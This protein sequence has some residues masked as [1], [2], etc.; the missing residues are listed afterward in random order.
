MGRGVLT[1]QRKRRALQIAM[2]FGALLT[3]PIST[4]IIGIYRCTCARSYC[5]RPL[6]LTSF[7]LCIFKTKNRRFRTAEWFRACDER[8][9]VRASASPGGEVALNYALVSTWPVDLLAVSPQF[10]GSNPYPCGSL[11]YRVFCLHYY[12]S[13]AP[14]ICQV[15]NEKNKYCADF[16]HLLSRK[17]TFCRLP[18]RRI[19]FR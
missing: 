14:Y 11:A 4:C 15:A 16:W 13:T 3:R 6:C 17:K 9:T 18:D 2:N 8:T 10:R 19:C 12:D 1:A 5:R 7:M